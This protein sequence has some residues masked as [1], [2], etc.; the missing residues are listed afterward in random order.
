MT[1]EGLPEPETD[2]AAEIAEAWSKPKRI[3]GGHGKSS[4]RYRRNC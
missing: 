4:R 1:G 2:P 3:K